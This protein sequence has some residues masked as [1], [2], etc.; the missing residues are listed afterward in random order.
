MGSR[1]DFEK[2][3]NKRSEKVFGAMERIYSRKWYMEKKGGLREHKGNIRE[4]W[5]KDEYRSK[6][7][8]ED[9]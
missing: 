3:K 9:R 4:I 8:R 5:G 2:K 6:E 7:V 1:K